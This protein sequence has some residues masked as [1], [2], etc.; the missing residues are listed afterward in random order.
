M[1]I[2]GL[3]SGRLSPALDWMRFKTYEDAAVWVL[4]RELA[5]HPDLEL[6]RWVV[7]DLRLIEQMDGC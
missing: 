2:V 1:A 3:Q 5:A 7:V 4:Q 6:T